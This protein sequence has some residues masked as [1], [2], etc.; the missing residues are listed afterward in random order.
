MKQE[1]L[2]QYFQ[3]IGYTGSKDPTLA[4][5]KALQAAHA[6][7]IPFETFDIALG[8]PIVLELENIFDKLV[9]KKE[10]RLLL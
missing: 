7:S 10:G 9:A 4:S 8:I 2:S 6:Y 5:L 1:Q 3:R